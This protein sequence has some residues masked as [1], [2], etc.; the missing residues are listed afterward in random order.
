MSKSKEER[1][2]SG[3]TVCSA[4]SQRSINY[5]M[6]LWKKTEELG[7][8]QTVKGFV[9]HITKHGSA[10]SSQGTDGRGWSPQDK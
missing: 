3:G 10:L 9:N 7:K 4:E 6:E 2:S 1:K 8:R 5:R